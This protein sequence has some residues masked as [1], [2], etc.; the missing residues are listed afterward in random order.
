MQ[1][2]ET[3]KGDEKVFPFKLEDL[4]SWTIRR[5]DGSVS[6]FTLADS[7]RET[8]ATR[9]TTMGGGPVGGPVR[10]E[11]SYAD[12]TQPNL[13]QFCDHTPK[14]PIAEFDDS[15]EG[16]R[17]APLRLYVGDAFGANR[18][19]NSFDFVIDGGDVISL[20]GSKSSSLLEGDDELV[21]ALRNYTTLV[22]NTRVLK[23]SWKD[24]E[25]PEVIPEFW[26]ELNKILYGDVMTCCQGGHGRSGTAFVCL[27]MVNAPD[28]SAKDAITHLRAVHCPRAIE[29]VVQHDYINTVAKFLGR[30]ENAHEVKAIKDYKAAFTASVQPT[31]VRARK[32]LG[33][34]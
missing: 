12:R 13:K 33:W 18:T 27:L 14:D 1:T 34:K 20:Y 6:R 22:P 23:V 9:K 8:L 25:A 26:V 28:Y 5:T 19:K 30:A 11:T 32:V 10:Q 31:A 24:R 2:G 17:F 4:V 29:S 16:A 7:A 15:G 21:L 3:F